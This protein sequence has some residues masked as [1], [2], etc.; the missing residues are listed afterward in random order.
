MAKVY[1]SL[2][3]N[4]ENRFYYINSAMEEI[5]IQVGIITNTSDV[6]ESKSWSYSDNNYLNAVI[7]LKTTLNPHEF[8]KKCQEIEKKLG[9]TSK[10][11]VIDGKANYS[12]RTID[13]DIL[14]Y[15]NIIIKSKQLTVPH[16]NMHLRMFVL[17]P[18]LQI[19]PDF[20]HPLI[21]EDINTLTNKCEDESSVK[22]FKKVLPFNFKKLE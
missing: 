1:L 21:K 3:S 17:K 11:V 6:W 7:E 20:I 8:L 5:N 22:F 4:I 12:S 15:D 10:T 9:R 14:F 13:I 2:G 18:L 19:A 16:Y